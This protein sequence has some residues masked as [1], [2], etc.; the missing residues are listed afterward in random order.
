MYEKVGCKIKTIAEILCKL[1]IFCS[2]AAGVIFFIT[3]ITEGNDYVL[4]ALFG[5]L[6]AGGGS[7][8]VWLGN[9][10]LYAFGQLVDD[11]AE[12]RTKIFEIN[13][14]TKNLKKS[15]VLTAK[16][17]REALTEKEEQNSNK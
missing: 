6:I 2:I 15:T 4:S 14:D 10:I 11:T 5:F 13:E 12:I 7:L 1:E 9:M 17:L 3:A 16:I 8:A